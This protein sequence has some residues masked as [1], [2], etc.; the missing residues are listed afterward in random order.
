MSN[1]RTAA[2]I[3]GALAMGPATGLALPS[4]DMSHAKAAASTAA[5]SAQAMH[6]TKGVVKSIDA[7]KLV[8]RRSGREMS[9]ALNPSTQREGNVKVGSPVEVRYR[10]E[11]NHRVA[12]VVAAE[13]TKTTASAR[14]SHQ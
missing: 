8:I 7:T 5:S 11:A 14:A 3:I 4:A 10:T 1:L 13:Q 2:I 6:A 9:F 12:T